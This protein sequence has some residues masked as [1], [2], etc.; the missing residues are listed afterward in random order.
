[1]N[2]WTMMD[3]LVDRR[4]HQQGPDSNGLIHGWTVVDH[5]SSKESQKHRDSSTTA[6]EV[7]ASLYRGKGSTT[8][9]PW[10]TTPSCPLLSVAYRWAVGGRYPQVTPHPRHGDTTGTAWVLPGKSLSGGRRAPGYRPVEKNQN[11][12]NPVRGKSPSRGHCER[13]KA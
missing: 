9:H 6:V 12:K 10:H 4:A 1:M 2:G 3:R 5:I 7:L 11:R 13:N 8:V